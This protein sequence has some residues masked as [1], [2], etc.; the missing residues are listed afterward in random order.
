MDPYD[1]PTPEH[2][3]RI[4]LS[5]AVFRALQFA[6][7][8]CLWLLIAGVASLFVRADWAVFVLGE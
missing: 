5:Q 6:G 4:E 8:L 1:P 2:P 3:D 7:R